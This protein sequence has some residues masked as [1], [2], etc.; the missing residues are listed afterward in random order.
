MKKKE[1]QRPEPTSEEE[2]IGDQSHDHL[3]WGKTGRPTERASDLGHDLT[4][5]REEQKK[6]GQ[7]M[8][9][10]HDWQEK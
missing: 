2:L 5:T 4:T 1:N 3:W 9:H 7:V 10:D 8:G 6:G